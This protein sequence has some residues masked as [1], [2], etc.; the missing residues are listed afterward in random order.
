MSV[1][2]LTLQGASLL[3]EGAGINDLG[4]RPIN[5]GH[6][7][8]AATRRFV[9]TAQKVA[10]QKQHLTF[11]H[12]C[13]RYGLIPPSLQARPPVNSYRGRKIAENASRQ[14]LSA[15]ITQNTAYSR[16]LQTCFSSRDNWNT[17]ASNSCYLPS[18]AERKGYIPADREDQEKTA[19]K[20][21]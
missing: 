16:R 14:Y 3:E 6:E 9:N 4:I 5:I 11:N 7:V 13:K 19:T 10:I 17:P 8:Q 12:R 20:V 21:Y 1:D 18:P 15:R 2:V